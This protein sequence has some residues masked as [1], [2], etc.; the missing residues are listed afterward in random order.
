MNPT[1]RLALPFLLLLS[2]FAH[3][4]PYWPGPDSVI[5]GKVFYDKLDPK[6][7]SFTYECRRTVEGDKVHFVTTYR[8]KDGSPL[9][10][11]ES[12]LKGEQLQKHI[13]RQNQTDEGGELVVQNAKVDFVYHTDGKTKS[14]SEDVQADMITSNTV[15][16]LLWR[17]WDEL[18]KGESVKTRFLLIE[19]TESIG[20]KFFIDKER[21]LNGKKVVDIIMKPS[22]F[23]IAALVRPIRITVMKDEPHWLV[24]TDGRLPIRVSEVQPVKNR[25]DYH[26]IDARVELEPPVLIAPPATATGTTTATAIGTAV[27]TATAT[28]A[29]KKLK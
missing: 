9:A 14:D 11:D 27:T 1:F 2:P 3:A 19:R 10:I 12:F 24:E 20:F 7:P 21:E 4:Q 22:S 26:A 6:E 16:D 23:I 18:V 28:G 15:G 8:G 5:R 17:N 13:Y 29:K 25:S